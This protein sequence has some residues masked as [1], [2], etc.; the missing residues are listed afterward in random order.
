MFIVIFIF[1]FGVLVSRGFF[2]MTPLEGGIE[3]WTIRRFFYGT[4]HN[5]THGVLLSRGFVR[6]TP[7][8]GVIEICTI[9]RLFYGMFYKRKF[10]L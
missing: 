10:N 7:L 3:I 4:F 5:L 1:V 2:R 9:R 6:M 8:E